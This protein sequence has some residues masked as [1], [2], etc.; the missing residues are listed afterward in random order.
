[1]ALPLLAGTGAGRTLARRGSARCGRLD[2]SPRC[3]TAFPALFALGRRASAASHR[4][5][6][7]TLRA[8]A[9]QRQTASAGTHPSAETMRP[10]ALALFGL[11]G[12]FHGSPD[13]LGGPSQY[14]QRRLAPSQDLGTARQ[15][16]HPSR[17]AERRCDP[18]AFFPRFA[19]TASGLHFGPEGRWYIRR[20]EPVGST[21]PIVPHTLREESL[22]A[23]C[24]SR[25]D[26]CLA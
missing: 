9:L 16:L 11:I 18:R 8:A 26:A 22:G 20:S 7:A 14:T 25:L 5:S 3:A 10:R 6:L 13:P 2:Q 15:T 12:A 24:A 19:S 4:E 1:V 17:Q 23:A 21:S